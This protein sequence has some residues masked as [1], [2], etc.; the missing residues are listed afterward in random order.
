MVDY[1]YLPVI[2]ALNDFLTKIQTIGV[3][4][5]ITTRTLPQLGFRSANHRPIVKIL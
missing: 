4:D 2:S 1:P 3:P 5:K